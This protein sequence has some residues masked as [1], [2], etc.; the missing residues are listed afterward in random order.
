V[1][2]VNG[3]WGE[4]RTAA[5]DTRRR[6][7]DVAEAQMSKNLWQPMPNVQYNR[8]SIDY[9]VLLI[10]PEFINSIFYINIPQFGF[11]SLIIYYYIINCIRNVR[12]SS[13]T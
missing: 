2:R 6:T 4:K 3:R 10:I 7:L 13:V 11:F 1:E 12:K 5:N 8:T 9:K